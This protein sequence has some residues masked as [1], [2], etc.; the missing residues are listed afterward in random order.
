LRGT[1]NTEIKNTALSLGEGNNTDSRLLPG[2]KVPE[3]RGGMRGYFGGK[4]KTPDPSRVPMKCIG[5]ALHPLPT[6]EG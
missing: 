4:E 5:T 3:V 2:E 6:G 1:E